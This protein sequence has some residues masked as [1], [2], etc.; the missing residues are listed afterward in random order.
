MAGRI[1]NG[2]RKAAIVFHSTTAVRN[3][4]LSHG[5]IEPERLVHA[6]Y[7]VAQE[8]SV[9]GPREKLDSRK[10]D[11]ATLLHVGSCIPRKRI[12]VL[13]RVFASARR[14]AKGLDLRLLQIG[15]TWTPQQLHLVE[16]LGINDFTT[17]IR[18]VPVDR[19]VEAYR[20]AAVVLVTSEMEG[21]GLPLIEALACGAPVVASDIPTLREVGGPAAV[22]RA[23]ADVEA[24][25]EAVLGVLNGSACTPDQQ[26]RLAQAALFSWERHASAILGAYAKLAR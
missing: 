7:G 1:L 24:W 26:T 17:Q 16:E 14:A 25:T 3:E 19:I 2:M 10:T 20:D 21:F 18:N 6:P 11:R 12:D 4:L 15:G 9:G 13:L 8:F 23:V 5:V 22:F